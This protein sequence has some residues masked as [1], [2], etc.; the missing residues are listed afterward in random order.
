M[1]P[2]YGGGYGGPSYAAPAPNVYGG[3]DYGVYNEVGTGE[4]DTNNEACIPAEVL[5]RRVSEGMSH[6]FPG[7]VS[8][9]SRLILIKYYNAAG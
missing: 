6:V 8:F 4:G 5:F 1:A 7:R 9:S 2:Q 3:A